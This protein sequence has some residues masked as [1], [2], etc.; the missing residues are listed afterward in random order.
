MSSEDIRTM[1]IPNWSIP[2]FHFK[3]ED[4]KY[5]DAYIE[6]MKSKNKTSLKVSRIVK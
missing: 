3:E 1:N 4:Y 6:N 2:L 5:I